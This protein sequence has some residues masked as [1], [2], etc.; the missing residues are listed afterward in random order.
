MAKIPAFAKIH[1]VGDA[2]SFA[3]TF[4]VPA[5]QSVRD[6]TSDHVQGVILDL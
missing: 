2:A 4:I 3:A 5:L 1:A 6:K